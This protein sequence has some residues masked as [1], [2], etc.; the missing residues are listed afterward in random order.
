[1]C[2]RLD[3]SIIHGEL[4][5]KRL[6]GATKSVRFS[7]RKGGALSSVTGAL[8]QSERKESRS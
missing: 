5:R 6:D 7:G 2:Y 4:A 3:V 8:N 1:M